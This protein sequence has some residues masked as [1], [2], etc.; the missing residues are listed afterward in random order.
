MKTE[1]ATWL[2]APKGRNEYHLRFYSDCSVEIFDD[3]SRHKDNDSGDHTRKVLF[4]TFMEDDPRLGEEYSKYVYS[5]KVTKDL[6][7]EICSATA[8]IKFDE[9]KQDFV[10]DIPPETA[11]QI[12][13]KL[14]VIFWNDIN[15]RLWHPLTK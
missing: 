7:D 11:K 13:D 2:L 3:P 9:A 12:D 14:N 6:L 10:G 15:E 1:V 4:W 8:L 5:F